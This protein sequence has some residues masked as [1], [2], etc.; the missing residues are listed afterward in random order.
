[1]DMSLLCSPR[2]VSSVC[3]HQ[4]SELD[5]QT[6]CVC[7]CVAARASECGVAWERRARAAAERA[8][9]TASPSRVRRA[10]ERC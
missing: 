1:M 2:V 5:R 3:A 8:R 10:V 7:A 6:A 4:L 9:R